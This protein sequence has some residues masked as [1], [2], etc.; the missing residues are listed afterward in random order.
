M[1]TLVHK[2]RILDEL[3]TQIKPFSGILWQD[4][5]ST[6]GLVKEK[7]FNKVFSSGR[8]Q[9]AEIH[10]DGATLTLD[11][12]Q[13]PN[14]E[15]LAGSPR[16]LLALVAKGVLKPSKHFV[17]SP[18]PLPLPK[19]KPL[20]TPK[21]PPTTTKKKS[22]KGFLRVYLADDVDTFMENMYGRLAD[23]IELFTLSQPAHAKRRRIKVASRN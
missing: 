19:P 20:P 22:K 17:P 11:T 1:S 8:I 23:N 21:V 6:E 5:D 16:T 4:L 15:S 13:F 12:G 10:I 3:D 18:K 7:D 2:E 14:L 9:P